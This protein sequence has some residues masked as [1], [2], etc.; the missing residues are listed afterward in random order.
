MIIIIL[1][2]SV[3]MLSA[4]ACNKGQ[5]SKPENYSGGSIS[6]VFP[7][8]FEKQQAI[9]MM[10]PSEVYNL[11][12]HPVNPVMVNIIKS[13]TPYIQVNVMSVSDEEVVQ[14]KDLLKNAGCSSTNV[15]YY[16]INHQSIWARDVGP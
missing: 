15:H 3:I 7:G 14:I 6:P 13:L 1:L 9:W 16:I 4:T 10:W 8:E 11:N 5:E 2:C 12:N